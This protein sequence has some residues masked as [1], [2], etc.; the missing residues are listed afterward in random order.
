MYRAN[1]SYDQLRRY[2]AGLTRQ[3]II[4]RNNEGNYEV[5]K[6]G[7]DILR[8]VSTVVEVL[9]DLRA[10]LC[11]VAEVESILQ[12]QNGDREEEQAVPRD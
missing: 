4:A 5:T 3:G 9:S 7:Q 11:P 12:V 1:L 10:E 2:L 6:K 8:R